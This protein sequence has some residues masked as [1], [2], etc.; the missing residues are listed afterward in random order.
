M[1]FY[2]DIQCVMNSSEDI[3]EEF[4][5]TIIKPIYGYH[6]NYH[7][8]LTELKYIPESSLSGFIVSSVHKFIVE[9]NIRKEGYTDTK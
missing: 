2:K 1:S 5:E 3:Q 8:I 7:D 4:V 6:G 9:H